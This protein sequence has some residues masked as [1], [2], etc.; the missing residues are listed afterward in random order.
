[1]T[2]TSSFEIFCATAP[3][4]EPLLAAEIS[5]LGFPE[6][7]VER[8]GVSFEGRWL[9]VWRANLELRGASRVLARIGAF[10]VNH[11]AQLDKLSRRF[12]WGRVLRKDMAV[13]VE[14][15]SRKSKIYHAGAARQ[16]IETA[17]RESFGVALAEEAPVSVRARIEN[18]LCTLSVDTSGALLHRRGFKAAVNKAP[19]RE[20]LAALFLRACE[21][22]GQESLLDPMC[23]SGTF[24]IEAA[25]MAAGLQPGRAR[26]FAFEHLASFDRKAFGALRKPAVIPEG[27]PVFLGSDRDA[28]AIEMSRANAERA[29][30]ATLTRF[31]Q[32]PIDRLARPECEPGL[33]II[34]PPYGGRIGNKKA[35][36]GVYDMIG[37][38][39]RT[40]FAGW[41]VGVVTSDAAL[42]KA[43]RL[44]FKAPGPIVDHGGIKVRLY[45]TDALR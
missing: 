6:P 43:T 24:V 26:D 42:A 31:E 16:R 9:D 36:Y 2:D 33:V 8:G 4:L 1:M 17:L 22:T 25:E 40:R 39:L 12:D 29:G 30:L 45:Q 20:N 11:L 27:L 7:K 18:N 19:M 32:T 13:S 37:Q 10:H 23:G 28:G 15:T 21:Y 3:G 41:R 38:S 44:P 34:N 14:V 5:A 35:L